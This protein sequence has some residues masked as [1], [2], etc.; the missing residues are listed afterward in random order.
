MS[1]HR[2]RFCVCVIMIVCRSVVAQYPSMAP[3]P[4]CG[5]NETRN[6]YCE[7]YYN[8]P[9][10]NWDWG[11]CCEETCNATGTTLWNPNSYT[12]WRCGDAGPANSGGFDCKDPRYTL[13]PSTQPTAAPI[14]PTASP[15]VAT[16]LPTTAPTQCYDEWMGDARCNKEN[17]NAECNYDDGDCCSESCSPYKN[18]NTGGWNQCGYWFD[19]DCRDPDYVTPSPT[20]AS[21]GVTYQL[22]LIGK[23]KA[24]G[25]DTVCID[26]G[27]STNSNFGPLG[28]WTVITDGSPTLKRTPED[29]GSDYYEQCLTNYTLS[30]CDEPEYL[31]PDLWTI[32]T[33]CCAQN[34]WVLGD[35]DNTGT[36]NTSIYFV[37]ASTSGNIEDIE[38]YEVQADVI[39]LKAVTMFPGSCA[40]KGI[41]I[42]AALFVLFVILSVVLCFKFGFKNVE[43]ILDAFEEQ[44]GRIE[45]IIVGICFGDS[46]I[47]SILITVPMPLST[48]S[49]GVIVMFF[50]LNSL[51]L[52]A[53]RMYITK[54]HIL[55][56]ECIGSLADFTFDFGMSIFLIFLSF[57][58]GAVAASSMKGDTSELGF[59]AMMFVFGTYTGVVEEFLQLLNKIESDCIQ[60]WIGLYLTVSGRVLAT[61]NMVLLFFFSSTYA[62]YKPGHGT[63]WIVALVI[64]SVV[65]GGASIYSWYAYVGCCGKCGGHKSDE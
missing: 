12:Y 49:V 55:E 21:E 20:L 51:M 38:W 52:F 26:H 15:S 24:I 59:F 63:P 4:Q 34:Y 13:P 6:G 5:Y 7:R 28:T 43:G 47:S 65:I 22:S 35:A 23:Y 41:I 16:L 10:C 17:N 42:A 25:S 58:L 8:I 60:K 14:A 19:Y 9:E 2:I 33:Y 3:T 61:F 45:L 48:Q 30:T 11:D 37:G 46:F 29:Y 39:P 18:P 57:N 54:A 31:S 44:A 32:L 1:S 27:Y 36:C 56:S 64:C 53:L 62:V 50:G 40:T